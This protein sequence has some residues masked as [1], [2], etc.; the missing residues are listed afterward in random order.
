M[1]KTTKMVE[2]PIGK[3]VPYANNAKKHSEE[4]V[5]KIVASIEEFGFLSPCLI[6]QDYNIIAGHGRVMAAEQMGLSKVPCIFVEGLTEAQRRAYILADNRLTELGEWD[7]TLVGEELLALDDMDFVVE[8]TGFE[9]PETEYKFPD[10]PQQVIEENPFEDI[11]KLDTHYGIP[12]QGNKSRIADIIVS[13][14]P[15]GERLVDLFGGG[16]RSRIVRCSPKSGTP[17]CITTSTRCPF[18]SLWTQ[19]M[20]SITMSG[21]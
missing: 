3:L 14:L 7:M 20:A 18:S 16:G 11:E 9:M 4:Q 21:A 15:G 13:I 8:L 6:D 12:Y 2:V 10:A 1:A 5:N 19:Y 17:F